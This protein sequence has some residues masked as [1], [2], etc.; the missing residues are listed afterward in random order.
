MIIWKIEGENINS[1]NGNVEYF[2][3][4]GD[5]ARALRSYRKGKSRTEGSG[6]EKVEIR[7]RDA[8]VFELNNAVSGDEGNL[9]AD[10]I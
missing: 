3:K 5:A 9:L 1:R 7:G 8:L 4:K 6:P 10:L 2:A